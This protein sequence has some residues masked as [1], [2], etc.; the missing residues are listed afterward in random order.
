VNI[1]L[2]RI[3]VLDWDNLLQFQLEVPLTFQ[4]DLQFASPGIHKV[5]CRVLDSQGKWSQTNSAFFYLTPAISLSDVVSLEYFIDS[6]PGFGNGIPLNVPSNF[7]IGSLS[8]NVNLNILTQGIHYMHVRGK[9]ALGIWSQISSTLVY[10][11][12][13][14]AISELKRLEYFFDVDPGFGNGQPLSIPMNVTVS[15]ALSFNVGVSSLSEG[16]HQMFVRGIDAHGNWSQLSSTLVFKQSALHGAAIDK[17]EYFF[18]VDPGF[19][20]GVEIPVSSG[21]IQVLNPQLSTLTLSDG[22]HVV[23]WR[24]RNNLK[25]WSMTHYSL[26][27]KTKGSV[28]NPIVRAEYFIDVDPG[29]GEANPFSV[30]ANGG[31][32]TQFAQ[33]FDVSGLSGGNHRIFWRT[34]D[35]LGKWSQTYSRPFSICSLPYSVS[36]VQP[37]CANSNNGSVSISI[38]ATYA[39]TFSWTPSGLTGGNTSTISNLQPGTYSCVISTN[40]G[41]SITQEVNVLSSVSA[42][43]V[44][45]VTSCGPY[46]W[47]G[48][49]YSSS[50]SYFVT[51]VSSEGC[52]VN[53]ILHLVVSNGQ[54]NYFV[55]NDNDGFGSGAPQSFCTAPIS[56]FSPVSGDCDDNNSIIHPGVS[57]ICNNLDDDCNGAID[58]GLSFA[59][60]YNDTDGDGYGSGTATNACQS[61]GATYVTNN[62]DCLPTNAGAYPG[63]LEIC[64]NAID[65]DCNDYDLTC[66]G[67]G[68]ENAAAV[69]SIGQFGTG[70][71]A[72]T[73]V[74]FG[75]AVSTSQ[76]PGAGLDKW[77][78]FTAV[79][80]AVRIGY[81]G[82][83]SVD[84]DNRLMLF[85]GGQPMNST[86]VPLTT[87]DNV[88]PGALGASTDGGNETILYDDLVVGNQYFVCVQ[89]TN[90]TPGTGSM[91]V[92]WLYGS[93]GDIG[94]YTNYTYTYNSVCQ[95]FKAQFRPNGKFYTVKRWASAAA[96]GVPD[97]TYTI[98]VMN[99]TVCQLGKILSPNLTSTPQQKYITVDVLYKLPNAFGTVVDVNAIG[100]VISSIG[101]NGEGALLVRASDACPIY[102][103]TTGTIATNRSV[104]GTS[105]YNWR[106]NLVYPTTGLP[107][108]V[109]GGMG[110][111]RI[112]PM[113]N[114]SGI[115]NGQRYDVQIKPVHIDNLNQTGYSGISCVRT[116][117]AAGMVAEETFTTTEGAQGHWTI[118][119]N[120]NRGEGVALI[121]DGMDGKVELELM[122]ATGRLLEKTTWNVED[123]TQ[124]EW[125]FATPLNSGL[126][127]IRIQQGVMQETLRM[128]VVR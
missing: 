41:C 59:N 61:P 86:W 52:S 30:P 106:F 91:T 20:E 3:Q 37:T 65:E 107:V 36:I 38:P 85:N 48:Q 79:T 128:V 50:G 92:S 26:F 121:L 18:D 16:I 25:H 12:D 27:F 109:N 33:S 6:D 62:T 110:A 103:S 9:N 67:A 55:D 46:T 24:V 119:P 123:S 111:S 66:G 124:R 97:W 84:D 100:N 96:A 29:I 114:I 35:N 94:P 75:T 19:D 60:Y 7:V 93:K 40:S 89:N 63:A 80:N 125:S 98:P 58:N 21:D 10:R 120:P 14:E 95:N 43:N 31:E 34:Q 127:E 11:L 99:S 112:M 69:L 88:H 57:E 4:P 117:G 45:Q 13:T 72:N 51:T 122:D 32:I 39:P 116:L 78:Q 56:G 76:S 113:A 15:G 74:N 81:K 101:L 68:P 53:N 47:N 126:Y 83:T 49:Q 54:S 70:V 64:G 44:T 17:V 73:T 90:I 104:C 115:A 87:E 8:F 42:E 22:A 102:K 5:G 82:S 1:S 28:I 105:Y 71:Q 108:S 118:Y 23:G 2:I 77:Y